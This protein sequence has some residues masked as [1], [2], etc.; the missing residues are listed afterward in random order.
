MVV[1]IMGEDHGIDVFQGR[2]LLQLSQDTRPAVEQ[3][4]VPV[5]L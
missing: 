2:I 5:D 3:N 4:A 1:V